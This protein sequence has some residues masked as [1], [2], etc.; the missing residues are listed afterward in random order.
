MAQ[1][2]DNFTDLELKIKNYNKKVAK[3]SGS[4]SLFQARRSLFFELFSE[5]LTQL[6]ITQFE[7][8]GTMNG[9]NIN[10]TFESLETLLYNGIPVPY[11]FDANGDLRLFSPIVDFNPM[12]ITANGG[13]SELTIPDPVKK[14]V[15]LKAIDPRTGQGD[16]VILT[17]KNIRTLLP[18]MNGQA[19]FS[20]FSRLNYARLSDIP[21]TDAY[22]NELANIWATSLENSDMMRLPYIIA[23]K[24]GNMTMTLF[25]EKY[26]NG[27]DKVINLDGKAFEDIDKAIKVL[28][29][30][31]PD[32]TSSL[33]AQFDEAMG[34]FLEMR[35]IFYDDNSKGERQLA[36]EAGGAA[37]ATYLFNYSRLK[38]REKAFEILCNSI[39]GKANK[40]EIQVKN[41]SVAFDVLAMEATVP[42]VDQNVGNGK[43]PGVDDVLEKRGKDDNL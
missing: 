39:K 28:D 37:Q 23:S 20:N 7:T 11:G 43:A 21:L 22:A 38:P 19:D 9:E 8:T 13:Y 35:G 16:F 36:R 4:T 41:T 5:A 12:L 26:L 25:M 6:S 27:G 10:Y 42:D 3:V 29:L 1:D 32:F 33:K 2:K 18:Y 17:N 34:R 30:K 40:L 15:T 24:D 14:D 31:V